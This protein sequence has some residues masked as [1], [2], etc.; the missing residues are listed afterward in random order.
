MKLLNQLLTLR[1]NEELHSNVSTSA[2]L[3]YFQ[4]TNRVPIK[5]QWNTDYV[6]VG[7]LQ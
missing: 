2:V 4:Q 7:I 6:R 1:K 3:D 5:V